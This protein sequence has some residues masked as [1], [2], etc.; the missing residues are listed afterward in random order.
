[1]ILSWLASASQDSLPS[2]STFRKTSSSSPEACFVSASRSRDGNAIDKE[3]KSRG[4]SST[5]DE[6]PSSHLFFETW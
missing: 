5:R 3:E 1:M 6:I 4:Y 2:L